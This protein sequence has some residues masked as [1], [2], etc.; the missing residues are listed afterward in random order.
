MNTART[1]ARVLLVMVAL[2]C[3]LA[4]ALPAAV[5]TPDSANLDDTTSRKLDELLALRATQPLASKGDLITSL[6]SRFLGTPYGANMLIGSASQPEQ[7]VIDFRAVDCFTYLDYV[8]A[9]TRSTDRN[10]FVAN[11]IQTRYTGGQVDFTK[12]KHFFTDWA[13]TDRVAATDITAS[14]TPATVTVGKQLNVKPD[15][16]RY[17]PGIPVVDRAITY[18]PSGSV[19]QN[20]INQL[21]PGDYIGAYTDVAG[22]D[23]SHVGIFVNTASGPAF[24]NA[25]S[26]AA[27]NQVVDSSFSDYVQSV[28]GIVVL[29]AQ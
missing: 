26:L 23:V 22:L 5:A 6:S 24:R 3:G 15:G 29:R 4:T 19:D 17:L 2:V 11:L 14:L 18:I 8:E 16:S 1:I 27:N 21:R 28:P 10:Q 13:Q 25:S 12:R 9:L 20:V 7:L